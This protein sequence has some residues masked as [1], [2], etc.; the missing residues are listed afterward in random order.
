MS[1][2]FKNIICFRGDKNNLEHKHPM[3]S[4]VMSTLDLTCQNLFFFYPKIIATS[5]IVNHSTSFSLRKSTTISY[6]HRKPTFCL[7]S[8]KMNCK[9]AKFV[10]CKRSLASP[11]RSKLSAFKKPGSLPLV[12]VCV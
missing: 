10:S 1:P 9:A 8:L 6:D 7:M 2:C 4:Y 3:T 5:F 11:Y 12:S